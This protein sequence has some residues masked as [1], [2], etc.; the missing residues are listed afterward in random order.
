M[1]TFQN[2]LLPAPHPDPWITCD[3][4]SYWYCGSQDESIYI[5]VADSLY[6]LADAPRTVVWQAPKTGPQ[7][8]HIWAPELHRINDRWY[9]LYAA[10]DGENR[11]HRMFLLESASDSPLGPYVNRGKVSST[12]DHWAIDGT[13]LEH[14]DGNLYLIWSGWEGDTDGCQ[15]LY[16]APLSRTSPWVVTGPRVRIS[17]PEYEWE[18]I[19][20]PLV[21]EGPQV[22][23]R[24][25]R[26]FVIYSASGSW[27]EDYCLGLL[28][29][30]VYDPVLE[31]KS[32]TKWEHPVFAKDP[33]VDVYGVG[34]ASYIQTPN[35]EW[36]IAYHGMDRPDG[37]WNG[38]SARL[39]RFT[40]SDD[41][42]PVFGRPLPTNQPTA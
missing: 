21:N 39:Q 11:N 6:S 20:R 38:R 29:A 1:S 36:W 16:I 12:D 30:S 31:P 14:P 37:G 40:W 4:K 41:G 15:D 18:C 28:Y 22:M 5:I 34:H 24:D 26:L 33:V 8:R 42:F 13:F 7:S 19:G 10:D 9:I 25:G 17:T 23:V 2:P 32:W 27:T 35:G 3:G